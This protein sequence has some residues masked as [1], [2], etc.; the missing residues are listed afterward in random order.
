MLDHGVIERIDRRL[1]QH[2][3]RDVGELLEVPIQCG[4]LT[5]ID[6]EIDVLN[7]RSLLE[8][9]IQLPQIDVRRHGY[10]RLEQLDDR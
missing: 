5:G 10:V 2:H 9:A 1:A 4:F 6:Q 3:G 7:G 8:E